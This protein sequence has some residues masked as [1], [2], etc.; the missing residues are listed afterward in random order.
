MLNLIRNW[1][2][3]PKQLKIIIPAYTDLILVILV[4]KNELRKFGSKFALISYTKKKLM[5]ESLNPSRPDPGR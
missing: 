4:M 1:Y 2:I 5:P 3:E